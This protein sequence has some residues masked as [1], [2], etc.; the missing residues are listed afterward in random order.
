[1][2]GYVSMT[3]EANIKLVE[4]VEEHSILCGYKDSGYKIKGKIDIV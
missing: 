3:G 1:V 4:F 2:L